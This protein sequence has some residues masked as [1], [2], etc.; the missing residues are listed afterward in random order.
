MDIT[1]TLDRIIADATALRAHLAPAARQVRAGE[2]LQAA[3]DAGG[4]IQLEAGAAFE[5]HYVARVPGTRLLGQGAALRGSTAPALTIP[6]GARDV[7]LEDL[8]ASTGHPEVVGVGE[9]TDRQTT[10]DAAPAGIVLR[11]VRI[12]THRGKRAFAIH[13][14]DV[15]LEDCVALD[16][17]DPTGQDSQAVYIGNAPGDVRILGGRYSAGSEVLLVGG[18][19]TRIPGLIPRTVHVE[20]AELFRPLSWQTDGVRRKVKNIVELKSGEYVT[21]RSNRLA[22]SWQDGQDGWAFVLTPTLDGARTSPPRVGGQVREVLIENNDVSDVGSIFQIAGRDYSTITVEALTGIVVR[23]NRF[24]CSRARFGGFGQLA[25]IGR[26]PGSL[27][28]EGNTFAGDGSS[29]IYYYRDSCLDPAT[30]ASRPAGP[31]G[32]LRIV[33][34]TMALGAYGFNLDGTVNARAWD[35]SVLE[36]VVEGNRFTG[37][38]AMRAVFPA[39]EYVA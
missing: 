7:V 13:G 17:W 4:V 20:G 36:M 14:W 1:G 11:R 12:P 3:L 24:A 30:G 37:S 25:R 18:D 21:I 6:P 16:V 19:T 29:T 23:G 34:N 38:T 8:D 27:V 33:D 22:G 26:E 28:F 39:N 5:G 2:S 10:A 32:S 35:R 9:N 31:I 15:A